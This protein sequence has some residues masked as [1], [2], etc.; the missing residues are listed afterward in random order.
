MASGSATEYVVHHLEHLAVGDGFWTFHIDTL[1]VSWVLGLIFFGVFYSVAR[2]ASTDAPSGIQTFIETCVEFIDNQ[3]SESFHGPKDF[4][5]PLALTI[6]VWVLLWNLMDLIPVDLFP[7]IMKL[8]GVEYVRILPSAD[9]NATFGLSFS[10]LILIIIYSVKGKGAKGFGKELFCHPFGSHPLLWPANLLLNIV[11]L[12]AKP[13]SLGMRL[14]GNL[15]AAEIIFILI[16]LLPIWAQWMPGVA[17]AVFHILVI[18]LQAFIFM[19]LT[20]VYLSLAYE[21]H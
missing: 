14:F 6:F 7:E 13:V 8:F 10:V 4:V 12:I 2:K 15:Y 20:I 3:V 19:V 11:E 1:V 21:E 18:P 9:M 5:A 17:W 16:A